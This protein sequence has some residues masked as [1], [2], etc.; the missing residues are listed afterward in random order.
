M[1]LGERSLWGELWEP[2][3]PAEL[4]EPPTELA[5]VDRILA[6]ERF[7][8]PWHRLAHNLQRMANLT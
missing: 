3:L 4:R 2:V 5:T 7:L 8:E 6:E 1:M